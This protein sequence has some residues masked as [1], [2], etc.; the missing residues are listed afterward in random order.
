MNQSLSSFR[1]C[2]IAI[3]SSLFLFACTVVP[4]GPE[5][6]VN[7]TSQLKQVADIS[8]WQL[9]GKI[10][11]RRGEEGA[12]ATMNW[13]TDSDDFNFRL[14][15]LLGVTL[16]NL[17]VE[18]KK[19]VLEADGET[20][21]DAMPEPLIYRVTGMDIPVNS[22]L[23]W[24][25]GLPLPSDQFTLTDKGLLAT[26]TSTC[27][28]CQGWEVSYANYGSVTQKNGNTVWLPHAINLIQPATQYRE[29]TQ[30]KIKIYKWTL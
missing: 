10:A 8:Q 12:S 9:K 1:F 5:N 18:D 4:K 23:S 11:F 19:A 17:D 25:K 29:K 27:Q 7:L 15:N 16:V 2:F 21:V 30:L 3:I 22:L 26:L 14:T 24:I 6:A 13:K 28:A 20:F